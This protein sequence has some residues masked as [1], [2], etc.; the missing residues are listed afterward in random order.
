MKNSYVSINVD[1]HR[2]VTYRHSIRKACAYPIYKIQHRTT[3]TIALWSPI[4][5][6]FLGVGQHTLRNT[7][8]NNI[9]KY[10]YDQNSKSKSSASASAAKEGH[11]PI[12]HIVLLEYV[13]V[14][15]GE[16]RMLIHFIVRRYT[17]RSEQSLVCVICVL[18]HT[19]ISNQMLQNLPI[20]RMMRALQR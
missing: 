3:H 9:D 10:I 8:Q 6:L 13:Q 4:W 1:T 5:N 17:N 19:K 11:Q 7:I 12:K 15:K 2:A 16:S 14:P 18:M 20:F